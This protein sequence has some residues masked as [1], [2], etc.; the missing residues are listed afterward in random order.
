MQTFDW[1]VVISALDWK[2]VLPSGIALIALL[3]SFLVAL[4]NWR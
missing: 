3:V 2:V 4:R 1:K